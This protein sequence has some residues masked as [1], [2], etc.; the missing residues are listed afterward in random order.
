M[1]DHVNFAPVMNCIP[2]LLRTVEAM[3]PLP[4]GLILAAATPRGG[5]VI[6]VGDW[7]QLDRQTA[8][9]IAEQFNATELA[10]AVA[11]SIE[12]PQDRCGEI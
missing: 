6:L 1:N 7:P 3:G 10:M 8:K 2:T 12:E 4:A 5:K 9:D 11:A